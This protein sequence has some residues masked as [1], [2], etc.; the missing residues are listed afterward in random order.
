M[1]EYIERE[2]AM[3][4]VKNVWLGVEA[5]KRIPAADV[6]EV[7]RCHECWKHNNDEECPMLSMMSCTEPDSFCF[8]GEKR[9]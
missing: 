1:S 3:N 9:Q 4:A 8:M 6:E 2:A 5:I 7:I